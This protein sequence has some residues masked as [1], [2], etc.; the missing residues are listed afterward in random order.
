MTELALFRSTIVG[1]VSGA[2]FILLFG[3][4][5][6]LAIIRWTPPVTEGQLRHGQICWVKFPIGSPWKSYM[7]TNQC[8]HTILCARLPSWR[9]YPIWMS[10]VKLGRNGTIDWW[11]FRN[12]KVISM[13][14]F[15]RG[16][17]DAPYALYMPLILLPLTVLLSSPLFTPYPITGPY[18]A[19]ARPV[20]KS[21]QQSGATSP[22]VVVAKSL[23]YQLLLAISYLHSQD[24]P[25]SHRDINPGNVLI[26]IDGTVK[27]VDFGIA[28]T[29][30]ENR[31][32]SLSPTTSAQEPSS[33]YLYKEWREIPEEMCCQ[34]AT[35]Y[36]FLVNDTANILKHHLVDLTEPLNFCFRL[37]FTQQWP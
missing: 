27:L 12:A 16:G 32:S 4:A 13:L 35:G 1:N 36:S 21:Q 24:P 33:T 2:A 30:P 28:W 20:L 37:R 14:E 26:D 22:F 7:T 6:S 11:L 18:S 8:H 34:V 9:T 3:V 25:I 19:L 10:V 5:E 31:Q 15:V 17:P 23:I 29:E